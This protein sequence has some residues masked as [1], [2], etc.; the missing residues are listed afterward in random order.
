MDSWQKEP[1]QRRS[2]DPARLQAHVPMPDKDEGNGNPDLS[3][4]GVRSLRDVRIDDPPARRATPMRLLSAGGLLAIGGLLVLPVRY[5]SLVS[6]Y[7]HIQCAQEW[8]LV[9]GTNGQL[10]ASVFNYETGVSDGYRSSNFDQGSSVYFTLSPSIVPGHRVSQGDTVG[11]VTSSETQERLIALNGQLAAAQG[12]VAVNATGSKSVVVR[13]AEQRLDFARRKMGEGERAFAR[14]KTLYEQG[15]LSPGQYEDAEN[16]LHSASD[17]VALAAAALEEARSGA[18]P[19]Q[20]QLAQS[21]VAALEEEIAALQRRASTYTIIAPISGRVTRGATDVL[22]T[23]SDMTRFVAKIPIRL[24]DLA[25]VAATPNAR[26][27]LR[28]LPSPVHGTVVAVD[29]EVSMMGTERV[30][31]ATAALDRG[32]FELIPGLAVR[33]D[34]A[35]RPVSAMDIVRQFLQ[36]LV[37]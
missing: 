31:M 19:E 13:A 2:A 17:E 11:V 32:S 35:C 10:S 24:N 3:D 34:I 33:C 14:T 9:K 4:A 23:I 26:V 15:L 20:L 27:T 12:L 29:Q 6:T 7:A 21:N 5:P 1:H 30:V 18:K 8:S 36:S 22:L 28:G 16:L 37:T 25:R